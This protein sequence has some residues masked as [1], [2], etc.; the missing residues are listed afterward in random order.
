MTTQKMFGTDGVRAPVGMEPMT[1]QTIMRLAHACGQLLGRQH[2]G[3]N[4]SLIHI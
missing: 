1:P 2:T 3:L 4:L